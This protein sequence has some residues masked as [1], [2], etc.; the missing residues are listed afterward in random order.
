MLF[1]SFI[2]TELRSLPGCPQKCGNLT[3]PFP[4]G[5][6]SNCYFDDSFH[7]I[8]NSSFKP[9]KPFLR[10]GR[11][12]VVSISLDGKLEILNT[13]S[14]V[15]ILGKRE[16]HQSVP[17]V[18]EWAT[19]SVAC[20]VARNNAS[21]Y[22]CQSPHSRC[23][24]SSIG[25]GYIC[26]C[27]P[28]YKGNPYLLDGCQDIDECAV[29]NPCQGVCINLPGSF[30]CYC[31]KGSVGDGRKDGTGC[32]PE[33]ESILRS[34]YLCFPIGIFFVA[35][36]LATTWIAWTE[37]QKKLEKHREELFQQNGG[38]LLLRKLSRRR[39]TQLNIYTAEEM[40]AI[41]NSYNTRNVMLGCSPGDFYRGTL[42]DHNSTEVVVVIVERIPQSEIEQ[43]VDQLIFLSQPH[44]NLVRVRGCCLETQSPLI[45]YEL[46]G[47]GNTTLFSCIRSRAP[48]TRFSCGMRVRAAAGVARG[49]A[50]LNS[51]KC[52]RATFVHGNI[53]SA[54]ILMDSSYEAK[55]FYAAGSNLIARGT[56]SLGQENC[57]YRDPEFTRAGC[58]NKRSDVYSFGVVLVELL[59]GGTV[60][61]PNRRENDRRM[62]L[63]FVYLAKGGRLHQ[64]LDA[65]MIDEGDG[66]VVREVA[67]LAESCL[68]V[69]PGERPNMKKVEAKLTTLVQMR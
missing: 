55:I 35:P 69:E 23:K 53:C 32:H 22:A 66:E 67:V 25:Q 9:P 51:H 33:D 39:N 3:I 42:L 1:A 43:F 64:I 12:E 28:G 2:H 36:V 68:K 10:L 13:S 46:H 41:T 16:D 59:T 38:N 44:N 30:K 17:M 45:V 24:D 26:H 62:A 15:G 14:M 31:P 65:E 4:F 29:S 37:R 27:L 56:S 8:C 50:Y 21:R 34:A 49:V 57:V 7:I 58:L 19:G 18:V 61:S 20:H 54:N 52:N 48:E 47:D 5:M 40:K 6:E 63:D 11:A 60:F